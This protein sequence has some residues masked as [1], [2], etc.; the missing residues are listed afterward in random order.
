MSG[1]YGTND[2]FL[3]KHSIAFPLEYAGVLHVDNYIFG[4]TPS[5]PNVAAGWIQ[6]KL[7]L[8]NT[9]ELAQAVAK[10]VAERGVSP[11]EAVDIVNKMK[12]L[13]GFKRG[14]PADVDRSEFPDDHPGFIYIEGRQLK[15]A[16]KEAVSVSVANGAL[17]PRGWGLTNKSLNNFF[18]EHFHVVED[19]LWLRN[20]DGSYIAGD[21][22]QI[23]INQSFIATWQGTGIQYTERV[24]DV[25]ME[26]TIRA[27][28]KLG[29]DQ[30][31]IVWL[32]GNQQG[33]GATRSQG[34]GRYT[35]V[36]WEI[37]KDDWETYRKNVRDTA[38]S[39]AAMKAA[40][41]AE[42]KFDRENP[43]TDET[44][45]DTPAPTPARRG[46]PPKQRLSIQEPASV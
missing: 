36:K 27:S 41:V 31:A 30:W 23:E 43:A 14:F 32:T 35:I 22:D 45:E 3:A 9:Q 4:G 38:R 21:S 1:K 44:S 46:R 7:G 25:Y 5:N 19:I 28:W 29:D 17:E 6:A 16:L 10:T 12:N 39:K 11:T 34:Y 33:I 20:A 24:K 42:V 37:V 40:E 13:N 15:A 26:F 2:V 18:P 8:S